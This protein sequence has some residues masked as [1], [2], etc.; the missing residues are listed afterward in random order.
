MKQ[1]L[2][3]IVA[4]L[5]VSIWAP[6]TGLS[7]DII[8]SGELFEKQK[9]I[10][11]GWSVEQSGD[12]RYVVFAD[13]FKAKSGPDLKLFLSPRAFAEVKGKTAIQGS[14][15]IAA[16]KKLKGSQRYQIPQEIDLSKY[17]SLLIHCEK[18]AVLWGGSAL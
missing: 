15:L 4:L 12:A 5:A 3:P 17:K 6:T 14:A 10:S 13:N 18:Y 11:G 9:A 7:A 2:K 8:A 16:L 1:I